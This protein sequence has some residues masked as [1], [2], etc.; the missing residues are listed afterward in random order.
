MSASLLSIPYEL[1]EQILIP[2]I[3]RKSNVELQYPT[4]D[5]TTFAFPIMR[6]CKSLRGEA[7]RLFYRTNVFLWIIDPEAV[8]M[9]TTMI[10][11]L[12]VVNFLV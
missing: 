5:R 1:R 10:E 6:V 11:S 3:C 12:P 8:S 2:L 9:N 7:I 4:P